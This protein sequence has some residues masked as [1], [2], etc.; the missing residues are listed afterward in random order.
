MLVAMTSFVL[1]GAAMAGFHAHGAGSAKC[2]PPA[3]YVDAA[4]GHAHDHGD[5]VLHLH[6]EQSADL[7]AGHD[8]GSAGDRHA[9][10][11]DG[12]CCSSVCSVTLSASGSERIS[13]PMGHAPTVLPASQVGSGIDP[14]GLKRPPRTPCIV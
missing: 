1:H 3:S 7:A 14:S 8:H 5:G 6:A 9:D 10:G 4:R 2:K 11:D 12:P 13:A